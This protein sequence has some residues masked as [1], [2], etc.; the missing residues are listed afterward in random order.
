MILG[1]QTMYMNLRVLEMMWTQVRQL[2]NQQAMMNA[3]NMIIERVQ[4]FGTRFIDVE[5]SVNDTVK[6]IAK[7]KITTSESGPS[8]ITA[9]RNLLVAGAK[10]NKRKKSLDEM[11][12]DNS[13]F[14]D[15]DTTEILSINK[16]E[17]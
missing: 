4:D 17:N 15:T 16:K 13:L 9:A 2:N 11:E 7:L 14:I 12:R 3:A 5:N 8:I 6:K 10:E 1:P